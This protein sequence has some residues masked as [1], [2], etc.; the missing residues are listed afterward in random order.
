MISPYSYQQYKNSKFFYVGGKAKPTASQDISQ[1]ILLFKINLTHIFSYREVRWDI[2][3]RLEDIKK[4]SKSLIL[5]KPKWK[6]IQYDHFNKNFS[7]HNICKSPR[8]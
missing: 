4:P 6:L 5:Y 3:I 2:K 1:L 8:H 7:T